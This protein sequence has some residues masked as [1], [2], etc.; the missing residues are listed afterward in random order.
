MHDRNY[1]VQILDPSL[2]NEYGSDPS[3]CM[4]SSCPEARRRGK[5]PAFVGR[6]PRAKRRIPV[7]VVAVAVVPHL[8]CPPQSEAVHV[9]GPLRP[10]E[11]T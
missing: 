11:E 3:L 10:S 9:P 6:H 8:C 1:F 4:S 2:D 7:F 5:D